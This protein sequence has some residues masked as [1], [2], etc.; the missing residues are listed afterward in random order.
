M[1]LHGLRARPRNLLAAVGLLLA[2][3]AIAP[4]R[5]NNEAD[6]A[7]EVAP[8]SA[9]TAPGAELDIQ[10]R[11]VFPL[12]QPKLSGNF[13]TYDFARDAE[14]QATQHTW[15]AGG[16]I[17]VETPRSWDLVSA[18]ATV[19]GSFPLKTTGATDPTLLLSPEA[20]SLAVL[21]EAYLDLRRDALSARLYRQRLSAP[22]LNDQDNR[23]I[24]STFEAYAFG[25]AGENVELG[26]GHVM[27][28]KT[29]DSD[30]FDSMAEVAGAP[31]ADTGA[32]V[33][34][35]Q[36]PPGS[37]FHLGAILVHNWDVISTFYTTGT[38][39]WKRSETFDVRLSG[40]FTYQRSVGQELIGSFDTT[41]AGLKASTGYRGGVLTLAGTI[42]GAGAAI[43]SPFGQRPSYNSLMLFNFDRARE[44]SWR[45]GFS[46]R[47]D[48]T[49]VEG[50]SF[51]LNYAQGEGARDPSTG[52]DLPRRRETDLTL[53]YRPKAGKLEGLWLR[54]RTAHGRDGDDW[55]RELR[56]ILNYEVSMG[57]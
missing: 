26:G 18:A 7:E 50:L 57:R 27:R 25:Y 6:L 19:Y 17:G 13:R 34:G 52:A 9:T 44:R 2:L 36:R 14:A 23:M 22:Y 49:G 12:L 20:D 56:V 45:I 24:P 47:L 46:N 41:A 1:P 29:R 43:Q 42:T 10:K 55:K 40:Q 30:E 8:E 15:A 35:A 5:A 37:P 11:K 38:W 53:D 3:I 16:W 31:S 4:A 39:D 33:I 51:V 28:M 21:G 32:T 48:W 54:L